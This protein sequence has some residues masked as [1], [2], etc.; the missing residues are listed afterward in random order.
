MHNLL[1][2]L[3]KKQNVNDF[4]ELSQE[5]K[6]TYRKWEEIL[7][8]REITEDEV[9]TFFDTEIDETLSKVTNPNLT[10]REDVFLKMKL[11]FL[12]KVKVFLTGPENERKI[13]AE[14]IK[15]LI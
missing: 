3:L 1:E 9:K 15:N 11:D 6:D 13:L 7:N 4:S 2:K 8:G 14:N 12:R 10:Q 5:E